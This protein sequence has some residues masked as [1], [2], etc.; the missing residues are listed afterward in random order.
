LLIAKKIALSKKTL[1]KAKK[2]YLKQKK[3]ALSNFTG[4]AGAEVH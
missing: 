1:L 3:I 4:R 2:H